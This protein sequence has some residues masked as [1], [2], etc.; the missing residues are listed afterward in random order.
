MRETE[1]RMRAGVAPS[2]R[3]SRSRAA[4]AIV[5]GVVV[6]GLAGVSLYGSWQSLSKQDTMATDELAGIAYAQP[7]S[8]L[9]ESLAV[10]DAAVAVHAP[11]DPGPIEAAVQ[12]VAAADAAHGTRLGTT[13]RWA[14]LK[15]RIDALVGRT[16]TRDDGEF[17]AAA[18]LSVDLMDHIGTTAGLA[19]D[20][21]AD[22]HF[23]AEASLRQLPAVM[24]N[25]ALAVGSALDAPDA[26]RSNALAAARYQ[27]ALAGDNA[28]SAVT[29]AAVS[30]P[31]SDLIRQLDA[32]QSSI[33]ALGPVTFDQPRSLVAVTS[34]AEVERLTAA[35]L[36]LD[37]TILNQIGDL[38]IDQQARLA[39]EKRFIIGDAAGVVVGAF[40]LLW[41]LSP[42]R[43]AA[44]TEADGDQDI[45]EP[46][47]EPQIALIEA[48]DLL[49]LEELVHVG[50]AVQSRRR[51]SDDAE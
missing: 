28:T 18:R 34:P 9:V 46:V 39:A 5:A 24:L 36:A 25:A 6:V 16:G 8:R 7:L 15:S 19:L 48:R 26:A 49:G 37:Q 14:D 20:S 41:V 10:A 35:A 33:N 32:F 40:V 44:I 38:L 45:A 31:G 42:R 51:A 2:A 11:A 17:R 21:N 23:L 47:E 13:D 50:R 12:A 30:A 4:L 22:I 3:R 1:Q 29:N 27:M 43:T